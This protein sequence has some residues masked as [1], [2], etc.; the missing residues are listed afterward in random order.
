VIAAAALLSYAVLLL[1]AGAAAL[2]RAR[3]ADRT[4]RLAVAA[5]LT[6]TASAIA[7]VILGAVAMVVPTVRV[8]AGLAT[9]LTECVLELRASYAHPGGAAMAGA[10]VVLGLAVSTRV[11][12]CVVVTLTRAAAARRRHRRVLAIAGRHDRRL[13]A[14]LVDHAEAAAWCLPGAEAQ[15]VL[16]TAAVQALDDIQLAAVLA[17]ERAHQRGHHHLLV[18]LAG[19]MAAAFPRVPAF[20]QGHEQVARLVELLADD[21]AASVSPRLKVAEAL[22]ALAAPAPAAV[23]ALGAGGSAIAARVRRLIAAPAP[24]GRTRTAAGTLS[25]AALA[26]F[27]LILLAGPAIAVIGRDYCPHA[28]EAPAVPAQTALPGSIV[29]FR[30]YLSLLGVR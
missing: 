17:H 11:S 16:T 28:V 14:V 7:S 21:A 25:V 10:G 9:L 29:P 26:A 4:P 12:W 22:L 30:D 2:T 5:W 3:W 18:A 19:S 8:S 13:D 6:L 15:V 24:V 27:P 20:R 1:T 23:A